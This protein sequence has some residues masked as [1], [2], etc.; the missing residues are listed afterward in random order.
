MV[1]ES[2]VAWFEDSQRTI[3][4]TK[5]TPINGAV[6]EWNRLYVSV[7]ALLITAFSVQLQSLYRQ[8]SSMIASDHVYQLAFYV[9]I[10]PYAG[11]TCYTTYNLLRTCM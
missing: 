1:Y 5:N 2:D 8:F 11:T 3:F 6:D 4:L 10:S 7:Y 9:Y